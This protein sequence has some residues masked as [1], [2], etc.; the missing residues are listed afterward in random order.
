VDGKTIDEAKAPKVEKKE[1]SAK[2]EEK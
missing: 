1:T 2:A